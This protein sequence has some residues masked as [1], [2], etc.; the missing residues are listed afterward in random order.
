MKTERNNSKPGVTVKAMK[1][2][3]RHQIDQI[4]DATVPLTGNVTE[5]ASAI[6]NV[7]G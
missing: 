6:W 2:M 5:A 7:D 3:T 1:S 4:S